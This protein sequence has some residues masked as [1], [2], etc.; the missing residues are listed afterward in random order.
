MIR[1]GIRLALADGRRAA[2]SVGLTAAAVAIGTAILLFA[3]S[4]QPALGDRD[5][6]QAWRQPLWLEDA[7]PRLLLA[8]LDD[9]Y[10]DQVFVRVLVARLTAD[11]PAP[12]GVAALPGPGETYVSPALADLLAHTPADQLAPRVGKV[13]GTIGPAGLRSP[14]EL[15]AIIGL[16]EQTLTGEVTAGIGAYYPAPV[17]AFRT[18]SL[19]PRLPPLALLILVLAVIG[20]LT[21]VAV[22]V[23]TA[24]RMAAA[25]R[26]Q[27]LA[28][29]R[30]V[31]ATPGQVARLAVA[32]ALLYTMIGAPLGIALFFLVRPYVALIPLDGATWWPDSIQPPLLQ[33][34]ALLVV[35][36]VVGAAAALYGMR[37]LA[38]SPLGV[39]QRVTPPPPSALRIVPALAGVAALM[40]CLTLLRGSSVSEAVPL[41][42][43]GGS[44]AAIIGGIAFAGPW[45]T[46]VVGRILGRVAR[47]PAALL[48]AR[49]LADDPRGSFGAIAG[50]IMAV[51]VVSAFFSFMAYVNQTAYGPQAPMAS[52]QVLAI[53]PQGA[54]GDAAIGSLNGLAGVRGVLPVR[55]VM[56][57]AADDNAAY[58]TWVV[59]CDRL[60]GP[61]GVLDLGPG[62]CSG[63]A[64]HTISPAS[65]SLAGD[66]SVRS[67]TTDPPP[68][69]PAGPTIHISPGDVAPLFPAAIDGRLPTI[70]MDPAVLGSKLTDF[71]VTQIFVATD[72]STSSVERVRAAIQGAA[73][74]AAVLPAGEAVAQ[75]PQF[76]E[77]G[78]IVSIGLI[79]SLALAGCS[80]AV[81][82]VTGLLQRRRQ[83]IFLRAAGLPMSRLRAL[84][85]I[86]TGVPLVVVSA[87]SALLGVGVAQAIL[88]LS[89]VASVPLPDISLL[90]VL[91][92][93]MLVAMSVVAATLPAVDR[94]TRPQ[95][96]RSE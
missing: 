6:R 69:R 11:A 4:F 81:A 26:E 19:P 32:E 15:I 70:V 54:P 49:R 55:E 34:V 72:G 16:D 2:F 25:N 62:R 20:A 77:L 48:A 95:S 8:V 92:A 53:L 23:A 50:V 44:F 27:R 37:R 31:G 71:P 60:V 9:R 83:F 52:G 22:F 82:T 7:Q 3:I 13:V 87:F 85:L 56:L 51:F 33:A 30:L 35:V 18:E 79:G 24:T 65:G 90:Y 57:N 45:L 91:A 88:R 61:G 21:P 96:L 42:I 86:Q 17:A 84:V 28:A 64:I 39:Q 89:P 73:P 75:K 29:L 40:I 66:F 58:Y 78:R 94:L 36:Q 38:I 10:Q 43:L 63:A 93:S 74:T 5:S 14:Q 46:V 47:G 41:V 76:A 80:L 67:T 59:A 68:G 12:P 1:L